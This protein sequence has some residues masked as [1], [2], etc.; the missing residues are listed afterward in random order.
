MKSPELRQSIVTLSQQGLGIR[1]IAKLLNI[2]RNTVRE[3]LRGKSGAAKPKR[4]LAPLIP[5][6]VELFESCKG[7]LVRVAE[8]LKDLHGQKIPYSS[9]TRMVRELELRKPIKRAGTY[10]FG[11]GK[12]C[13]HDTSPHRVLIADKAQRAQCAGLALSFSRRLYFQY[14]PC[15]TRFEAKVFLSRGFAFMQ[16]SC[17]ECIID[18][19]SVIVAQ[20]SGP[21]AVIAPEM[22][23]FGLIYN[24]RFVPHAIGHADRKAVIERAFSY[25]ENNF[26]AGRT[27]CSWQDLNAQAEKWCLEVADKKYKKSLGMTPEA[28]YVIEK[29]HMQPL[30]L[31]LAPVYQCLYRIVDLYGY[32]S[33]DTN[34]YSVPERLVGKTV[35]VHKHWDHIQ[36]LYGDRIVAEHPRMIDKRDGKLTIAGHHESRPKY[37]KGPVAEEKALSGCDPILNRYV[38]KIKSGSRGQARR[39]LQRLLEFKRTYPADAFLKAITVALEYGMLDLTRLEAMIISHVAGDFFEIES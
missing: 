14:Y 12:E 35:E 17:P 4:N 38:E 33:V 15:F 13:Q 18:N 10:S 16:G 29:P 9:L 3:L 22:Q 37:I 21:D 32:V 25:I 7:N 19:T 8:I 11:P 28:A 39:K 26:L 30:A 34:R 1:R 24:V 20:G 27:F 23:A 5:D 2:S 36:I 6:I 31:P